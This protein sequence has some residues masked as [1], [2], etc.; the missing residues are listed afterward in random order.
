MLDH[1]DQSIQRYI[2]AKQKLI[3]LLKEQR[4]AT[5]HQAVTG[6]IN[7]QSGQPYAAYKQ[8]GIEWLREVPQHWEE[9][10][11]STVAS[12]IQTGPFGSQLHA[13]EYVHGGIP[14]INPSHMRSGT[15]VPDPAV[16]TTNEKA[17]ELSRHYLSPRRCRNGTTWRSRSLCAG[18]G[19]RGSR[20]DLAEPAAFGLGQSSETFEPTYLLIVLSAGGVRDD[21]TLTSIG[22]TMDNLNAAMVSRLQIHLPPIAEQMAIVNLVD[23]LKTQIDEAIDLSRREIILL[24]EYWSALVAKAVTGVIGRTG[25]SRCVVAGGQS[26]RFQRRVGSSS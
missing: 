15:L 14:V 9:R 26:T 17:G 7:A 21:L 19:R 18:H 6:Q 5:I 16:S 20:L 25:G 12:S 4:Q 13:G 1:V 11:L 8:S 10:S 22:A 23:K 3:A 24:R 2:R